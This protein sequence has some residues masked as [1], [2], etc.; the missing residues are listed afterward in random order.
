MLATAMTAAPTPADA[1][2]DWKRIIVER[3]TLAV[4]PGAEV[5]ISMKDADIIVIGTDQ[6]NVEVEVEIA[7]ADLNWARRAFQTMRFKTSTNRRG[8]RISASSPRTRGRGRGL[9]VTVHVRVPRMSKVDANTR[10]GDVIIQN[11]VGAVE[12]FTADGDIIIQNSRAPSI[13]ARS[14]DGDLRLINSVTAQARLETSDGDIFAQ[15]AEGH[16]PTL[17]LRTRDGDILVQLKAGAAVSVRLRAE[18]VLVDG[19]LIFEGRRSRKRVDGSINDGGPMV[20]AETRDGRIS[21]RFT[22]EPKD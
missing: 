18:N 11:L 21:L 3:K 14:K 22:P 16:S 19:P 8:L 6:S 15:P 10:D 4:E 12:A 1:V 17:K 2:T 20:D 13:R 5:R 7:A 9:D